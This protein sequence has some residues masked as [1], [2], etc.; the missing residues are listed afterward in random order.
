[1]NYIDFHCDTLMMSYLFGKKDMLEL[2]N[3]M[4]DIK[5]LMKGEAKAQFFAI[6]MPPDGAE[7]MI[8][9]PV[10]EDDDYIDALVEIMHT[11]VS[12]Q[13]DILGMAYNYET[14]KQNAEQ[15]KLSAFLTI[16]DGRSVNGSLDKLKKYYEKGVR[17][18]S[19]TWNKENCFGAPNSKDASVMEKGLTPFGKEAIPYMNHLGMFIDVSHLSDGGFW[20]V[21]KLSEKP[22]IAS[23]SNCRS[24]C[25]HQ[26]NL[27][28]EMIRC[29]GEKGGGIG[30]NF[31]P[32]FLNPDV[33]CKESTIA[34]MCEHIDHMIQTG[35]EDCVMIGTDF[36]GIRG[37]FE[38]AGPDHMG[39]LFEVLE[40]KGYSSQRIEKIAYQNAERVIREVLK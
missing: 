37:N 40:R 22:F 24:I 14:L 20:D 38:I 19:L 26:R 8:G 28:D 5:R 18:M 29:I 39:N 31:G 6:F 17:L 3:A 30:V 9:R 10:P 4:V 13:S 11:T 23:H 1:M 16:E 35:G 15:G 32:E 34:R 7:K 12:N 2:P 25:P 21:A 36:D 27:T 33:T